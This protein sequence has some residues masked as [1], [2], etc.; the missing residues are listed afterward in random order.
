MYSE[1]YTILSTKKTHGSSCYSGLVASK[2]TKKLFLE[3][4]SNNVKTMPWLYN[5]NRRTNTHGSIFY[6]KIFDGFRNVRVAYNKQNKNLESYAQ[7]LDVGSVV[8]VGAYQLGSYV[9]CFN[10]SLKKSVYA[11]SA[12]SYCTVM[13]LNENSNTADIKL[14]S[15]A[16]VKTSIYDLCVVG[17][18]SNIFAKHQILGKAS[19]TFFLKKK[20]ISVRGVAKNPVDHPNGG[21]SKVKKP[22]RNVWG[23]VAKKN[24]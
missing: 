19:N 11:T 2:I 7:R 15:G 22:F 16:F 13:V 6:L 21:R 10:N 8:Y 4:T 1:P 20:K 23:A 9:Y 17:R 14:P 24:K 3:K 12:G 18:C 5:Y